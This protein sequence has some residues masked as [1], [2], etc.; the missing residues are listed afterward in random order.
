MGGGGDFFLEIF[1]FTCR[2]LFKM[3]VAS[4]LLFPLDSLSMICCCVVMSAG[5]GNENFGL[6]ELR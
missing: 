2:V 4:I 6:R 5:C 3:V 1:S